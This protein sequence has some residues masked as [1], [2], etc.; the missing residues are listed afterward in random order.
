[1][2]DPVR[3]KLLVPRFWAYAGR[4][5]RV[6][7]RDDARGSEDQRPR[8]DDDLRHPIQRYRYVIDVVVARRRAEV[9]AVV[10]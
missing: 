2:V 1:M 6:D 7:V 5:T 9:R 8:V 3:A 4:I 10:A